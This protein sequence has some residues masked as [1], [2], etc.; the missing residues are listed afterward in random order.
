[1]TTATAEIGKLRRTYFACAKRLG[2]D[3]NTRHAFNLSVTSR[4]DS[5]KRFQ[6]SDWRDAVAELQTQCG[7]PNV[8]PGR[9]HLKAAPLDLDPDAGDAITANQVGYIEQLAQRIHWRKTG[10]WRADLGAWI[11]NRMMAKMPTWALNWSGKLE[12]LPRE[13]ATNLILGLQK[14]GAP[15]HG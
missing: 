9:P 2:M 7:R 1:M 11:R 3:A 8:A 12:E 5:T 4:T 13:F 6:L 15:S 10:D 14:M